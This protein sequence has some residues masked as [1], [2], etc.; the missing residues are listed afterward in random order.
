MKYKPKHKTRE[1]LLDMCGFVSSQ[2]R[3]YEKVV[4]LSGKH[5]PIKGIESNPKGV[6]YTPRQLKQKL[7]N[8]A[9]TRLHALLNLDG[10]IEL[11]LDEPHPQD[12]TKHKTRSRCRSVEIMIK[13]FKKLDVS[14]KWYIRIKDYI[15]ELT[16]KK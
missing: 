1:N 9:S 16:T 7:N 11:H 14:D 4:H 8:C 13:Q 2:Q 15:L 3:G 12:K 5:R 6:L 10:E